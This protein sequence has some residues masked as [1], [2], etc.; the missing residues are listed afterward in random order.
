MTFLRSKTEPSRGYSPSPIFLY[1]FFLFS[2]QT[3]QKGTRRTVQLRTLS[4]LSQNDRETNE[5]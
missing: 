2:F 1:S 4:L 5:T 3:M